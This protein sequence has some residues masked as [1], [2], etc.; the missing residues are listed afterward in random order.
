MKRREFITLLGGA[1]AW[2]LV[3]RAQQ[4]RAIGYLS[5]VS[6]AETRHILASFRRGLTETGFVVGQ[7]VTIDYRFADGDYGRLPGLAAELVRKPVDLIMAQA[8]PAALAAKAATS[9]IPIVF[10]VGF[11]PIAAGLVASINRPGGNATGVTLLTAPLGQKRLE[12]LLELVPLAHSIAMIVNPSSPDTEAD[13]RDARAAAQANGRS[14]SVVQASTP[15]E[16]AAAFAA[17]SVQRPDAL[18]AGSDPF[19]I[20]QRHEFVALAARL[21]VPTVYPFR[22]FT[23]VGGLV[24]YGANI[25]NAFRQTGI[26]AGRILKGA[27]P[28]DLPV[29][30]PIT[31][32]LVINLKTAKT[33]GFEIP[34][35]LHARS[36]EVIE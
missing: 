17:V 16:L 8:P 4:P 33:L 11:D 35:T 25:A 27:K 28:A 36:D 2:P 10:A 23:E 20:A 15:A 32:E 34:P 29:L 14:L 7:S 5:S 1:A 13:V 6:E 31:F 18:L 9:E 3:A 19:F 22:E 21:G 24:S 12:V 26:Y 30:Q